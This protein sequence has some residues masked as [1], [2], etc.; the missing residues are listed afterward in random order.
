MGLCGEEVEEKS[1]VR[2]EE[3]E[4]KKV[5]LCVCGVCVGCVYGGGVC[6]CV[7]DLG[8]CVILAR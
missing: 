7:E 2:R 3:A 6:V 5:V 8:L 1:V 4:E